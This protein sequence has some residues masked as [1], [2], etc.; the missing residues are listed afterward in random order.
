MDE[1]GSGAI[2]I[3]FTADDQLVLLEILEASNFL[4]KRTKAAVRAAGAMVLEEFG[5]V[6][7][8]KAGDSPA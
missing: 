3:H 6:H 7:L 2:I 8:Q 4:A 5:G 1:A